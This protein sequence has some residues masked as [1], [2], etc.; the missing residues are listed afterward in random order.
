MDELVPITD[1]AVLPSLKT[2]VPDSSA[3]LSNDQVAAASEVA[4][5]Q[6]TATNPIV[7]IAPKEQKVL[8]FR[9]KWGNK[10]GTK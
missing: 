4:V 9:K 10:N 2:N 3:L 1:A 5:T 7:P 8:Y 6:E